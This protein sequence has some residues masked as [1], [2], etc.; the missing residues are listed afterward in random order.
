MYED[1]NGTMV[2]VTAVKRENYREFH[3]ILSQGNQFE[4][5]FDDEAPLDQCHVDH[6]PIDGDE[7]IDKLLSKLGI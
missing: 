1:E 5:M 3:H 7:S 2:P 6:G 4:A